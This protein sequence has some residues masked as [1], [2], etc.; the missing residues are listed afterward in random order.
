MKA[1][2][3]SKGTALCILNLDTRWRSQTPCHFTPG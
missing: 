1:Y 2:R 3:G